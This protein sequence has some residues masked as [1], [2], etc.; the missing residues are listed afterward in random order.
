VE[1][2][3]CSF[4]ELW[5]HRSTQI[6]RIYSHIAEFLKRSKRTA[7]GF[8]YSTGAMPALCA[9]A[10]ALIANKRRGWLLIDGLECREAARNQK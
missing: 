8:C 5:R 2:L 3:V 9:S 7:K 10:T 4:L 6:I 1:Y